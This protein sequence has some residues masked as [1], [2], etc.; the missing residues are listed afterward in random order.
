MASITR[1][2][3][4]LHSPKVAMQFF[5]EDDTGVSKPAFEVDCVPSESFNGS[6]QYTKNPVQKG[7]DI[8]DHAIHNPITLSIDF[9]VSNF[10]IRI[11]EV[12]FSIGAGI[13]GGLSD[14]IAAKIAVSET[15][16]K[17][18]ETMDP[19]G[20]LR[21]KKAFEKI[22][23]IRIKRVPLQIYS[24]RKEYQNMVITSFSVVDDKD[25]QES[26]VGSITF[27]ELSTVE[28]SKTIV[29]TPAKSIDE[30]VRAGAVEKSNVGK[31][32]VTTTDTATAKKAGS[33]LYQ[34]YN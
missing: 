26:L 7:V 18:R 14:N 27:E 8:S 30:S 29:S 20:Y 5:Y 24:R 13:I 12:P 33:W 19:E 16:I 3:E 22:E 1:T 31:K 34:L 17:L 25:T 21:S 23:E 6:T 32:P 2:F 9:I 28:I 11:E 15:I 4:E 10:P